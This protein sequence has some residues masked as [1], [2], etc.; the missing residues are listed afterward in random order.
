MLT[1]LHKGQQLSKLIHLAPH[2]VFKAFTQQLITA[3][4]EQILHPKTQSKR[5]NRARRKMNKEGE[6]G[7]QHKDCH[8]G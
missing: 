6:S 8:V 5:A 4:T 7:G 1:F 3:G 2:T